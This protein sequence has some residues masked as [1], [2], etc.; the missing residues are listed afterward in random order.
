MEQDQPQPLIP[1]LIPH[2]RRRFSFAERR[3]FFVHVAKLAL[4]R[5][6]STTSPTCPFVRP[7]FPCA[8]WP[9]TAHTAKAHRGSAY[10]TAAFPS[11]PCCPAHEAGALPPLPGRRKE[12]WRGAH[13]ALSLAC[14]RV[15]RFSVFCLHPSPSALIY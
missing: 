8:H 11:L 4:R 10:L 1:G 3:R 6:K 15:H 12:H 14:A 13:H 5:R 7:P 9:Q 2:N